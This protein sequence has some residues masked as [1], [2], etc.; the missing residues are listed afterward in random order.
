MYSDTIYEITV[1]DSERAVIEDILN[2]LDN[3]PID[4]GNC[5]YVDIFRSIANKSSNV[6]AD[7]IKILYE[8]GGSNAWQEKK[9]LKSFALCAI[10]TL[11]T[12]LT[13]YQ[14]R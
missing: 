6:D 14:R 1:N 11:T 8:L 3:C 13:T 7:G 10:A 2:I 9:Q 12:S 5:D 4:L